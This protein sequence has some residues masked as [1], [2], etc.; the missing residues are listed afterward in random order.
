MSMEKNLNNFLEELIQEV[1]K[2]LDEMT[3]T[4]AVGGYN[5]P[6]AF[7]DGGRK[8]KKR[9]KKIAT[10]LGYSVV[11]NDVGNIDEAMNVRELP[12]YIFDDPDDFED[13]YN[14]GMKLRKKGTKLSPMSKSDE[15]KLFILVNDWIDSRDDNRYGH[16][17]SSDI[18]DQ[19]KD[20]EKF[21]KQK[22]KVI[23]ESVSEA[24]VKRPVNRWLEL[25]NDETMHPHKKMAMGLK[26]LKYQL[27]ET[28]KF[29]NWYNKIKTMNE[30]DSNQYWKRTNTHI[31]KIK[32]RLINIAKTIQEIEK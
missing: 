30:L 14:G 15:R 17:S 19:I 22:G 4:G 7:S 20:I 3:G 28:E 11:G 25:K 2:E 5:T 29:F 6:A 32:E 18:D 23:K 21:L 24:K 26:E 12:N 10:S 16:G 9:K 13:W 31:Y 1:E 8:D 27:R